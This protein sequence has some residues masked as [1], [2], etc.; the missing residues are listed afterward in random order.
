MP[1]PPVTHLQFL[2]LRQLLAG[3]AAGHELREALAGHG[4]RRTRAAFYQV[5]ARLEEGGLVSGRYMA[6]SVNGQSVK[7]RRYA[8]TPLG[9]EACEAT[10]RF[11]LHERDALAQELG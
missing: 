8:V 4:V 7:E 3:E 5:M 2:V 1:L 11:Y 10:L 6:K 9:E